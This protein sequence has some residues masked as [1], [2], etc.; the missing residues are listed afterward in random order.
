M[1]GSEEEKLTKGR[2]TQTREGGKPS[3]KREQND[4]TVSVA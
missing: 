3:G 2:S 1:R 4:G